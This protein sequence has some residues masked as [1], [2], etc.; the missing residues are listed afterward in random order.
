MY[1]EARK[2]LGERL[3]RMSLPELFAFMVN[4]YGIKGLRHVLAEYA[5]V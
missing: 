4:G 5:H 3:G 1:A 2:A